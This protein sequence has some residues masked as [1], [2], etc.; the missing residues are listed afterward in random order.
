M[1]VIETAK[2][3]AA[4]TSSGRQSHLHSQTQAFSFLWT[5]KTIDR[6]SGNLQTISYHLYKQYASQFAATRNAQT[7]SD[8]EYRY[9]IQNAED[10][11]Q[12]SNRIGASKDSA[13][14]DHNLF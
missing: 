4:H 5:T 6:T 9:T 7:V 13:K 2:G 3:V 1:L 12:F 11:K 8:N 14:I 10:T